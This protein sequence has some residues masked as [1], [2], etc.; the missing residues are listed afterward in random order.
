MTNPEPADLTDIAIDVLNEAFADAPAA[1]HAMMTAWVPCDP[2]LVDH[3]T[4]PVG[5]RKFPSG[6]TYDVGCLDLLNGILA[7]A[8][9]DRVTAMF[10]GGG[11]G[12]LMGFMRHVPDN[13]N[14]T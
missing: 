12:D 13:K 10:G 5:T 1:L 3:P 9:A 8:G 2:R 4:I 7:A 14:E 6:D 11:A